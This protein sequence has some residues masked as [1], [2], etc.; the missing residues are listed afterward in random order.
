MTVDPE[1]EV[2]PRYASASSQFH[3]LQDRERT[4]AAFVF[5]RIVERIN[6]RN[7]R[8]TNIRHG[9]GEQA[10]VVVKFQEDGG[11]PRRGEKTPEVAGFRVVHAATGMPCAQ[12]ARIKPM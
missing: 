4:Q 9:D 5:V 12:I 11:A 3:L 10:I 6:R 2:D 7:A 1:A 8:G